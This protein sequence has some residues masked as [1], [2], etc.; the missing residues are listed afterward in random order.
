MTQETNTGAGGRF[1]WRR[2]LPQAVFESVLIVFSLLLALALGQWTQDRRTRERVQEARGFFAEEIALNCRTLQA[3]RYLPHHERL[4]AATKAAMDSGRPEDAQEA[5]FRTGV[6]PMLFHDAV[7]RSLST[8]DLVESMRPREVFALAQLYKMQDML[9]ETNRGMYA[10][11]VEAAGRGDGAEQRA[12]M[13]TSLRLYFSD[14]VAME[15]DLV[16]IYALTLRAL[17]VEVTAGSPC[18][19]RA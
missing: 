9:S 11:T 10:V 8:G 2:W 12:G 7:W 4:L 19:S 3:D 16:Q 14:V 5:A 15:R 1:G 17:D 6:H 18:G 13:A